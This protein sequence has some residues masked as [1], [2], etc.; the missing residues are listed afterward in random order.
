[1]NTSESALTNNRERLLLFV[2]AVVQFS[3]VLDFVIMMPLGPQFMRVFH[4]TPQEFGLIVSSY[5][6]SAA[7][8][9]FLGAFFIDRF[10][11]RT[12]LLALY[13]GFV[14]GT[15]ACAVAPN[16]ELLVVARAVAGAF[17]GILGAL[18]FAIVGDCI[19]DVRRGAATGVIMSS[20]SVASV[21]GVPFGL[22][23]ATSL[24]WHAPFFLLAGLSALALM[25]AVA[26]LPSMK[27]HLLNAQPTAALENMRTV[28]SSPNNLRAFGLMALLMIAGFSVIPF[29]SPY[30]VANVGLTE[31][32]LPYIYFFGGLATFFT[33]QWIGKLADKFGKLVVF[34]IVAALSII[35]ILLITN[36]PVVPLAVAL[37]CT[38]LFMICLSGRL[39]PA[40]AI[41]TSSVEPRY[42]GSFMSI[43]SAVMQV[44]SGA[45][46]FAAG[47][48]IGK[49]TDGTMTNYWLV[50]LIAALA[51][52]GCMII[53]GA[54]KAAEVAST[55]PA[56][57][58]TELSV[59]EPAC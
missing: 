7:I 24:S 1:M 4:I 40:M 8:F 9:G 25:L 20:F 45:G 28:L 14:L 44:F 31:A 49:A 36:L 33:S 32:D 5:T 58:L 55:A 50:G 39:V 47:F 59:S 41:I 12:A 21:L 23:L 22:F 30:M 52:S 6:F 56:M 3:H 34:R 29:I 2:L 35:P 46:S 11:R 10:D 57:P 43:N 19:P 26:V 17:G 16:Y 27:K 15:L 53:A 42:R 51:T 48:I 13:A 38:T 18:I 37:V 54:V